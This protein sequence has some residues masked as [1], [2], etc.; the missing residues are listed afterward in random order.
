MYK[1]V[2][3]ILF[4]CLNIISAQ[5]TKDFF[6]VIKLNDSIIIPYSV[7]LDIDND[8]IRG[9]SITDSGGDH[10]T[11]SEIYGTYDV[12]SNTITLK[13]TSIVYTKSEIT[14]QDFCF[15]NF[16]SNNFK[17]NSSTVLKGKFTGL[18]S[19]GTECV[20]GD[21]NMK[22][23][24]KLQKETN[25]LS[26]KINKS[27]RIKKIPDSLRK[28]IDLTKELDSLKIN[29]L[30]VNQKMNL[31]TKSN[32]ILVSFFD[33][34]KIDGDIISIYVNDKKI[35]NNHL[36]TKNKKSIPIVINS[37]QTKIVIKAV[38]AGSITVNTANLEIN[39]GVQLSKVV[40]SLKKG[41]TTT[42]NIIKK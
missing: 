32:K 31:F 26:K 5:S 3:I 15:V 1:K 21:I 34:G 27:R 18:F 35:L 39:D 14:E 42:I 7:Y 8:K 13:E 37:K 6:G 25:K 2:T 24:D 4:L 17:I 20:S 33:R 10:E 11:K 40:T 22:R 38:S 30:R 12:S 29:V 28:S 41:E 23:W 36:L 9:Y 19:D 16:K